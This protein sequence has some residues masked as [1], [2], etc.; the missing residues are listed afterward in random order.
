MY[1]TEDD[2]TDISLE[3]S[4]LAFP[5]IEAEFAHAT[6]SAERNDHTDQSS[7]TYA[8]FSFVN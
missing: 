3:F 6:N 1:I 2:V 5:T 4:R 7:G 8:I